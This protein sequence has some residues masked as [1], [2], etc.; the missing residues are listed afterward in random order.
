MITS[1]S[2]LNAL[3]GIEPEILP[4]KARRSP[5]PSYTEVPLP[6]K[7]LLGRILQFDQLKMKNFEERTH[8]F[9][10][11]FGSFQTIFE[12]KIAYM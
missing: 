1:I 7:N 3:S 8:T 4:L 5:H 9:C 2:V 11:K 10:N 6:G 12:G